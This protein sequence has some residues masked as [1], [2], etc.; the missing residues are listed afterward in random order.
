M[1]PTI[2]ISINCTI[3][4]DQI[5]NKG[6]ALGD[7]RLQYVSDDYVKAIERAGG[8]PVLLPVI[9][10]T[11]HFLPVLKALDGILFTGGSDINP[12]YYGESHSQELGKVNVSRDT[13][14]IALIRAVLEETD[15]PV[16][17]ICRGCQLMAVGGGGSLYQDLATEQ[18]HTIRHDYSGG[19]PKHIAV[20]T[21]TIREGS[22]LHT[23]C[24]TSKVPINSFHHQAVKTLGKGFE[25]IATAEDDT[26]EAIELQGERFVVG[27][28]WHP[29]LMHESDEYA[30]ALFKA[31]VEQCKHNQTSI[32]S[33]QVI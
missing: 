25:V 32:R 27:V 12:T 29:E 18:P 26:I 9:E 8:S 31:F 10:E 21:A 13:H 19:T 22:R 24:Q 16:L 1:R 5:L 6:L 28:Q 4:P 15:L 20:Q 7:Q 2:G 11:V 23:I 33:K 14:E 30:K 17:G 3:N